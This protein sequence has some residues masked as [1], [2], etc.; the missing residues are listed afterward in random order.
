MDIIYKKETA[1][2]LDILQLLE[3]SS[4]YFFPPLYKE[5]DIKEYAEKIFSKATTFEAWHDD[6]LVGLI[7]VYLNDNE[8][9]IGFITSVVVAPKFFSQGIAGNLLENLFEHV[10]QINFRSIKLQVSKDNETAFLLY[11]KKG[12]Q[13]VDTE[14][15]KYTMEIKL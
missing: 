7:A 15:L 8:T 9:N 11:K 10:K 4:E 14:G 3:L 1:T 13:T 5:V 12:F 6:I 2:R